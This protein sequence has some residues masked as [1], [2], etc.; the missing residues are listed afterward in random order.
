MTFD[1]TEFKER[2]HDE[3]LRQIALMA[4][5]QKKAEAFVEEKEEELRKARAALNDIAQ[6]KLPALMDEIGSPEFTTA[7]GI[8]ITV[9]EN[10]RASIPQICKAQALKWLEDN[11]HENL[12]KREFKVLF[13]KNEEEWAKEFEEMLAQSEREL[14]VEVNRGVHASTLSAFVREQLEQGVDIPLQLFGAM[15]QRV[16]K[17]KIKE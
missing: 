12:I 4:L 15:R 3:V 2:P 6:H 8:K 10:I 16:T 17:I 9:R 13:S 1:Y 14:N 7:D 11:D 5:E